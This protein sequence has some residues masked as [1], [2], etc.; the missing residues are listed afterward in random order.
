MAMIKRFSRLLMRAWVPC[1]AA[2]LFASPVQP[3]SS[4]LPAPGFHHVHMNSPNPSAAINE[5]LRVYPASRKIVFAGFDGLQ[6]GNRVMMLFTK[7]GERPPAPGPDRVSANAPQTAFWHHVWTIR[8]ARQALQALRDANPQ[9]DRTRFIPQ[10]TGPEGRT[11]DFS[12]D[13][14]P[15]FLTTDELRVARQTRVEPTHLGGYFNWYGP[16]GV[17]METAEGVDERY[18]I[19]GM[20]QEQPYCA[21]LWYK[22]HLNARERPENTRRDASRAAVLAPQPGGHRSLSDCQVSRGDVVTWPSTYR[23]GHHRVPPPQLVVFDEVTLRWYMNQEERPLVSTRG[24]LMDHIALS[25][26]DLDAWVAKLRREGVKLLMEPYLLGD[27]RAVMIEGPSL[28]AIE[29]VEVK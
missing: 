24:Q 27:T 11:V 16:D 22:T 1:L 13:A 26:N 25:V 2:G 17:V 18:T 4:Q 6:T 5:F 12:S 19:L 20:F 7:V 3:Q 28:E 9:F 29:L 10:Y 21:L 8:D 23:R 15:G 14:I